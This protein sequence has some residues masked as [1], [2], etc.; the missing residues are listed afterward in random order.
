MLKGSPTFADAAVSI[1]SELA[2]AS[3]ELE[4]RS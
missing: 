3:H 4:A 1:H 2:S